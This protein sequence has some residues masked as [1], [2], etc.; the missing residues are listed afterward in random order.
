M[1]IFSVRVSFAVMRDALHPQARTRLK[2][3]CFVRQILSQ[4]DSEYGLSYI[5]LITYYGMTSM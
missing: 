2:T 4:T 1:A 3:C 5:K